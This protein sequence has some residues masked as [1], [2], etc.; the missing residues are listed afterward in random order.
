MAD[1][2][3]VWVLADGLG[4]VVE[5]FRVPVVVG[6]EEG[7]PCAGGG[8]NS[9]V[10]GG[11]GSLVRGGEDFEGDV[12]FLKEA[13][14]EGGGVVGGSVVGDED[15]MGREG[16]CENGFQRGDEKGCG[17]EGGDDDAEGGGGHDAAGFRTLGRWRTWLWKAW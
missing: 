7:D 11:S 15:F 3:G 1:E 17:V 6:V 12:V 4:D 16:L 13:G 5:F 14:G 9:A 2:I 10:A 8:L